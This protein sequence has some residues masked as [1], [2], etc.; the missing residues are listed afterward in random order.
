[1]KNLIIILLSLLLSVL[2]TSCAVEPR[3]T[4]PEIYRAGQDY[5]HQ[6]CANCH[7]PD[8]LGGRGPKLIQEKFSSTNFSNIKLAKTILNGSD[9]GAMPSQKGKVS[10]KEIQEIIK[11]L[12]YSQ[13]ISGI[14]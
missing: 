4:V 5:Y 10:E 6:A 1:M 14:S 7:G 3:K 8:G 12:R 2:L 9:S 11:Y 13:K